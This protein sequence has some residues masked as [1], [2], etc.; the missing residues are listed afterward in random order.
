MGIS[1]ILQD[2]I[3]MLEKKSNGDWERWTPATC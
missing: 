1:E 3:N 2:T